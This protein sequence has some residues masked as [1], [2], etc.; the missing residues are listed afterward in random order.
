MGEKVKKMSLLENVRNRIEE[1][2]SKGLLGQGIAAGGGIGAHGIKV[3]GQEGQKP[4]EEIMNRVQ[5]RV[6]EIRTRLQEFR[7]GLIK[8]PEEGTLPS[9]PPT[10]STQTTTQ[11]PTPAPPRARIKTY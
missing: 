3:F 5:A 8:P 2:R 6:E 9:K 11:T 4:L 1:I 10:T 7:P